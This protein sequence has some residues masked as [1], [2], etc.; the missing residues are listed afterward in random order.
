MQL[1]S[2]FSRLEF[3]VCLLFSVMN[4]SDCIRRLLFYLGGSFSNA[5]HKLSLL[6]DDYLMLVIA[7]IYVLHIVIFVDVCNL[8]KLNLRSNSC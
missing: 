1:N 5:Y 2:M 8:I 6:V 7:P 3:S 4:S